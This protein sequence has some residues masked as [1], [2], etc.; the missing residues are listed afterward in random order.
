MLASELQTMEWAKSLPIQSL[1]VLNEGQLFISCKAYHDKGFP[2]IVK[3]PVP[4]YEGKKAERLLKNEFRILQ[5][6]KIDGI[7]RAISFH[8]IGRVPVLILEYQEGDTMR[9]WAREQKFDLKR[10]LDQAHKASIILRKLHW[11]GYLHRNISGDNFI[12]D[13]TSGSLSL[14][15]FNLSGPIGR[16][17]TFQEAQSIPRGT[18]PY[19]SPEL[20]GRT[21]LLVDHR[22]DL[23]SFGIMLYELATGQYPFHGEDPLSLIHSHLT[24]TVPDPCDLQPNLPQNIGKIILKLTSKNP[25]ERYQSAGGLEK[26]IAKC[27]EIHDS[28]DDFDAFRLGQ[29]DETFSVTISNWVYGRDEE[30]EIL[31][32]EFEKADRGQK[33]FT[34]VSGK[35][36]T[37]K[38]SLVKALFG[39]LKE[40]NVINLSGKADQVSIGAPF[41]AFRRSMQEW[42]DFVMAEDKESIDVLRQVLLNGLGENIAL[43]DTLVPGLEWLCGPFAELPELGIEEEKNRF[44]LSFRKFFELIVRQHGPLV[45]FLDDLQWVD[46]GTLNLIRLILLSR[47][48]YPVLVIGSFRSDE[49]GKGHNFDRFLKELRDE[50]IDPLNIELSGLSEGHVNELV[51]D[52]LRSKATETAP[53]AKLIHRKTNGNAFFTI[54]FLSL[55]AKKRY[56]N[57]DPG[58]GMWVW[59]IQTIERLKVTENVV[60]FLTEKL[61][62]LTQKQKDLISKASCLGNQF[63]AD[64]VFQLDGNAPLETESRLHEL[65]VA[66][67]LTLSG[68]IYSFTHDRIQQAAYSLIPDRKVSDLHLKIARNLVRLVEA[69]RKNMTLLDIAIHY[70]RGIQG[71]SEQPEKEKVAQILLE[72]GVQAQSSSAYESAL[73]FFEAGIELLGED[74]WLSQRRLYMKL[75]EGALRSSFLKGDTEEVFQRAGR[76]L[77]KSETV[78]E[79]GSTYEVLNLVYMR[80]GRYSECLA[81]GLKYLREIGVRIPSNPGNGV[82]LKE[83]IKVQLKMRKMKISDLAQLPEIKIPE[84]RIAQSIFPSFSPAAYLHRPKLL[85]FLLV[86]N[87]SL[88]LKYGKGPELPV[89]MYYYAV[90]RCGIMGKVN[91]G[92]EL[93]DLALKMAEAP[94]SR[95]YI[96]LLHYGLGILVYPWFR[97][98]VKTVEQMDLAYRYGL[99]NGDLVAACSALGSYIAHGFLAGYELGSLVEKGKASI[100]LLKDYKQEFPLFLSKVYGQTILNFAMDSPNPAVL[101][102]DWFNRDAHDENSFEDKTIIATIHFCELI[103]GVCF[104]NHSGTSKALAKVMEYEQ[105]IISTYSWGVLPVFAGYTVLREEKPN[106]RKARKWL[107]LMEKRARNSPEN[108]RGKFLILKAEIARTRKATGE[109]LLAFDQAIDHEREQSSL[110]FQA[111]ALEQRGRYQLE[112]DMVAPGRESLVNAALTYQKWGANGKLQA[113]LDEFPAIQPLLSDLGVEGRGEIRLDLDTVIKASQAI[114]QQVDLGNLLEKL[115]FFAAQNAGA[116]RAV[117]FLPENGL[118][119]PKA[120][121]EHGKIQLFLEPGARPPENISPRKV[122]NYAFR[123]M[124]PVIGSGSMDARQFY[125]DPYFENNAVKSYLC[126]PLTNL[127]SVVA[128]L[129]MENSLIQGAFTPERVELI[130]ILG[131]QIAISVENALL[132]GN[133]EQ[134][135]RERTREIEAQRDVIAQ[136]KKKSDDLLLNILPR[137]TAEELKLYGKAKARNYDQVTILFADV[138]GFTKMAELMAPEELV[139]LLD[140][141]FRGFDEI[142]SEEGI[143]KIKTIGDAYMCVCGLPMKRKD[144]ALRMVTAARRMLDFCDQKKIELEERGLKNFRFRIGIHS[145]SVVAGVVGSKK[146]AFDIWGDAVNTAARMEQS[147]EGMKINISGSTYNLIKDEISCIYRGRIAAKNKGDLEMYFVDR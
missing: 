19:V 127:G 135:V 130:K 67:L 52:T 99:R 132:I 48:Q 40:R 106:L 3:L 91:E 137:D 121:M 34:L 37:G 126:V 58:M 129:Y 87:I 13:E 57:Y 63:T 85:S 77:N 143:E 25:E 133:L 31:K 11:V 29:N 100:E 20:T 139:T 43:L 62:A 122:I 119:T 17:D 118:L 104:N 80:D 38:S 138:T 45:I 36:G 35:S 2:V 49:M 78:I 79:K 30:L 76:I 28:G 144:H 12:Y 134:K 27:I 10:F 93:A 18:L 108:F 64:E 68:G 54:Q 105:N 50:G 142:M 114:A 4:G 124:K 117:F 120:K 95:K 42:M 111:F 96:G 39:H 110:L 51:A 7:R 71:I 41:L 92:R 6:L 70:V 81:S 102:G 65:S 107:K 109:A 74:A 33:V 125:N 131:G 140:E 22:S 59:D 61:S 84:I 8:K 24:E 86:K 136:E 103:L 1:R 15:D 26:D 89:A 21:K 23:Y 98:I 14:I 146:F 83:L 47:E 69:G 94:E 116:N 97:P 112:L 75:H 72:A 141:Y 56:I 5:E 113:L 115:L 101:K 88:S 73:D 44:N 66:G 60:G 53:L 90:I 46:S 9:R 16:E 128:M 145:G 32:K 55:L 123:S 82:L 147:S